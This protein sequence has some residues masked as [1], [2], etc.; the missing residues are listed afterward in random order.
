MIP[1]ALFFFLKIVLSIQNLL[2]FHTN[3]KIICSSSVKYAIDILIVFAQLLSCV[4]LF[5]STPWTA[6]HQA[7]L[8][9]GFPRQEYWNGLLCPSPGDLPNR[10]I[11]PTFPPLAGGFFTTEPPGEPST[12]LGI[13]YSLQIAMDSM[14]ILAILILPTQE[15]DI[16]F[17][18]FVLSSIHF[19]NIIVF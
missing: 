10:G 11:S 17:H 1:P 6:A 16:S 2:C 14:I 18:L 7:P 19:I 15:H 9:M 12:L 3:C 13:A 4:R 5:S 8:S